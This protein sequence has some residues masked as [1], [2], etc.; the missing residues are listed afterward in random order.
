MQNTTIQTAVARWKSLNSRIKSLESEI[1]L[2][3]DERTEIE[4]STLLGAMDGLGMKSM[5]LDDGT[6]INLQR[7]IGAKIAEGADVEAYDFLEKSGYGSII[8]TD[9]KFSKGEDLSG[10]EKFLEESGVSYEREMG[11]HYKS[12]EKA[13]RE[14][15]TENEQLNPDVNIEDVVPNCINL[16]IFNKAVI[17][18]VK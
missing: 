4:N 18:E 15:V 9:L 3:K 8:K 6:V 2:L 1:E 16:N 13:I 14:I 10:V 7:F 12:L 5:T 11:V 17:K